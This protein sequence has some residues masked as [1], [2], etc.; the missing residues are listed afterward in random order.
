MQFIQNVLY[1]PI[2]TNIIV[3]IHVY[4]FKRGKDIDDIS[5]CRRVKPGEQVS[6]RDLV[7][8]HQVVDDYLPFTESLQLHSKEAGVE[9]EIERLLSPGL[10]CHLEPAQ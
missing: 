5:R 6:E 2:E 1:I 10:P 7:L 4:L 9:E 8:G 3:Y